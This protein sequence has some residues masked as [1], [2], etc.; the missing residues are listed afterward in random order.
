MI[1]MLHEPMYQNLSNCDSK[2]MC[3]YTYIYIYLI[4]S[5]IYSVVNIFGDAGCISSAV[6]VQ[7]R[8]VAMDCVNSQKG[9][10][11]LGNLPGPQ[12]YAK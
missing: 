6:S 9:F 8:L 1:E 3:I 5:L 7:V 11:G 10:T 2:C 12:Q 4:Y